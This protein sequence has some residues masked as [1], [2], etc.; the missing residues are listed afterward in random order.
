[1]DVI[2]L[3]T[4]SLP[5]LNHEIENMKRLI[6]SKEIKSV[7]AKTTLQSKSPRPDG[8]NCEF[9]QSFK[10]ELMP[11]FL[12]LFQKTKKDGILPNSFHKASV[13]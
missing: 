11:V 1:M 8:F 6:M 2:K 5:R 9:Y 4:C 10:E 12:R 3:E 13:I 7:K